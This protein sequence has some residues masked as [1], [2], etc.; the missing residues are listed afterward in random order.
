MQGESLNEDCP[1][2]SSYVHSLSFESPAVFMHVVKIKIVH[3][4]WL[5]DD[6]WPTGAAV[7]ESDDILLENESLPQPYPPECSSGVTPPWL[8]VNLDD[9]KLDDEEGRL[10]VDI[11]V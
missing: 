3:A 11:A 2:P 1:W 7:P 9:V 6:T 10:E 4:A 5:R 8:A